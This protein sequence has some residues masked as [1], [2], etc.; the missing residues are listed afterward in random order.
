LAHGRMC[1]GHGP[2]G[3]SLL[4][5]LL[6]F[7]AVTVD[8]EY[9]LQF[10][11][12]HTSRFSIHSATSSVPIRYSCKYIYRIK[13][14]TRGRLRNS[15]SSLTSRECPTLQLLGPTLFS[16]PFSSFWKCDQPTLRVVYQHG[17]AI[18][19]LDSVC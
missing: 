16:Y 3:H 5:P 13:A 10:S 8:K 2:Y 9:K 4:F 18:C 11:V 6:L 17:F 15:V 19:T 14:G 1:N 12:Q 7:V